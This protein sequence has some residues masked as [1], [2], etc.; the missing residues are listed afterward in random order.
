MHNSKLPRDPFRFLIAVSRPHLGWALAAFAAVFVGQSLTKSV[1]YIFQRVI[2]SAGAYTAGGGEL[3]S[4]VIWVALYPTIVIVG[5]LV[6]RLSGFMGL[7]W[8][9]GARATSHVVLFDYLSRHSAMFF[10]NRFAGA[11]TSNI[12][13]VVNGIGSMVELILWQ[14]FPTILNILISFGLVWYT[15]S[16][17]ALVFIGWLLVIVPVNFFFMHKIEKA[18]KA[19]A[20]GLSK[21]RGLTV[22][23]L[24][25]ILAVAQFVRR[26]DEVVRITGSA[27]SQ[28]R[29]AAK[30]WTI[31]EI[32]LTINSLLMGGF[33]ISMTA[34]SFYFWSHGAITLGQF[35]LVFTLTANLVD[36]FVFIG[37]S[38]SRIAELY[39]ESK[40]GLSE[41]LTPYE[42]TDY[43]KA[44]P[45][46]VTGGTIIYDSVSFAYGTRNVFKNFSVTVRGGERVGIVGPSGAGKTTFVSLLLRQQDVHEG[47]VCIDGQNIRKVTM[48]SLR[49]AIAIVPQEPLLFHRTIREN[50]AYGKPEATD[51][52]VR[53]A[54]RRAEARDFIMELPD[55]YQTL[56]GE[57]GVKLSGG[58]R[59]RV[60]IARAILKAAPILVLDEATSSLDSESESAIQKAL[61]ELMKEKT[62][63]AIAH[64]LSTIRA[65]D[66]IIVIE[67]GMIREDGTH[68]ELIAKEGTYARLWNHQAGGFLTAE[69]ELPQ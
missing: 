68:D 4:V 57:R 62:V 27:D 31:S 40:E 15:N 1:L 55:G 6:W 50:I 45:L 14:Y 24:S 42:V 13:N 35:V 17:V 60:A 63:I 33:V 65:M 56:V 46:A 8:S 12:T 64:R 5:E 20:D 51:E 30:S 43:P 67:G 36:T 34:A 11:L 54:A 25:N 19:S 41:I 18:A 69:E 3:S 59:Q 28:R 21:L 44:R 48:E 2:D 16:V 47:Q 9:T 37:A 32:G 7:R 39:G 53:E 52:E 66:R 26:G 49:A 58:Q 61:A 22:D 23:I 10:A 38:L 29:L